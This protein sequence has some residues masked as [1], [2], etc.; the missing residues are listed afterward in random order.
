MDGD[1][2]KSEKGRGSAS[3][4]VGWTMESGNGG[5]DVTRDYGEGSL[6]FRGR[7]IPWAGPSARTMNL[8]VCREG[9]IP[10]CNHVNVH[11]VSAPLRLHPNPLSSGY[12]DSKT[13]LSDTC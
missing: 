5:R 1:E 4:D 6:T 3:N 7:V 11:A 10:N 9:G 13:C 2:G 12:L 8:T